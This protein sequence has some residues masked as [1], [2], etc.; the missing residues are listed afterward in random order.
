MK[1]LVNWFAANPIAA[2]LLMGFLLIGGLS[3]LSSIDKETFPV[4]RQDLVRVSVSYPGASP[5]EVVQQICMR[6]E[7]SLEGLEGIQELRCRANQGSGS[8]EIEVAPDFPV[9]RMLNAVKSRVDSILTFPVE[10]ERPIVQEVLT[11]QSAI[12]VAIYGDIDER[13]L[14]ELAESLKDELATLPDVPLVTVQGTRNYEVAVEVPEAR[15]RQYGIS[16]ASVA[17]AINSHSRTIAGGLIRAP[18]GDI[19]IQLRQQAYV[20]SDFARIPV[21]SNPDGSQVLLSDIAE[22]RDGFVEDE[23]L[24]RFNGKPAVFLNV[25]ITDNPNILATTQRVRDFVASKAA[26]LPDSVQLATWNDASVFFNDR[27][28]TLRNNGIAGLL[29]V[30]GLLL[31]FLRPALALWVAVGIAVSFL[32]TLLV[33]PLVGASI[34]MI[35]MFAFIL[36][37]GIVVDDAIIIGENIHRTHTRRGIYGVLGSQV[38][39][40]EMAKPV[41]F[42]VA[43]SIVVFVPLF[44]LPGDFARFM[45]PIATIPIL[46]LSFSLLESLLI[47]PA[48]LAHLGPE[49]SHQRFAKLQHLRQRI[50][51]SLDIF[52]VLKYRPLLRRCLHHRALTVS[53]FFAVFLLVF[54]TYAA[55]WVRS[56]LLPNVPVEA[57]RASTTLPAGTPFVE[58]EAVASHLQQAASEAAGELEN[59]YGENVIENLFVSASGSQVQAVAELTSPEVRRSSSAEFVAAWERHIGELPQAE[60]FSVLG[61]ISF[62]GQADLELKLDAPEISQLEV[63]ADWVKQRLA[64]Y[65]GI[66]NIRDSLAQGRPEMVVNTSPLAD[67]L[68]VAPGTLARQLRQVFFGEEVQRIPRLREDVRV[69]VRYP[70]EERNDP[71][72]L[73][74]LRI[75]TGDGREV[76]FNVVADTDFVEGYAAIN[77]IDRRTTLSVT[78]NYET[79]GP[80]TAA[81]VVQ[82][83]FDNDY[84]EFRSLFPRV[85]L[86]LE[87]AQ[88]ENAE[89]VSSILRFGFLAL[90]VIYGLLAIQFNSW[91]QPLMILTAIPFA[92]TGT[93]LAHAFTGQVISLL[94][95]MGVLAAAGVVVN[96]TLVMI[97]RTNVLRALGFSRNHALVQAGR[98]R[99]RPIFLTSLT[100]FAGLAPLMLEK[101]TQAQFLIPMATALA[102]G[103]MA[104]TVVTLVMI[105]CLY[106]LGEDMKTRLGGALRRRLGWRDQVAH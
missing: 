80:Q 33:M 99:F 22:I 34:N 21:I 41:F 61:N 13:S 31:L 59:Q 12:S 32:G 65:P 40:N 97:D 96:D 44:Y 47:L 72:V 82:S 29:L 27:L 5:R 87:G 17:D 103:V 105:P 25:T 85:Q 101:S 19:Q 48:H 38:G 53:I 92:F 90:L 11:S 98:D 49:K 88:Q 15:L 37:L 55:G 75:R 35:T 20:E 1:S 79:E 104:A 10:A 64:T 26:E 16:L 51:R 56:A 86:S 42:A 2:N 7:E 54:A 106:S 68:G 50:A 30:F 70:R 69:M 52:L 62:G 63:A 43:T 100:T 71:Q 102:Y 66:Y 23:S 39:A 46:A 3:G 67:N 78:A 6:I 94:S 4:I 60:D 76:P 73:E 8:A 28:S 93:I 74:Q 81:E 9:D 57:I 91:W 89:F 14:K 95:F 24:A 45:A 77:R 18:S 58:L 83:F 84:A 36:V